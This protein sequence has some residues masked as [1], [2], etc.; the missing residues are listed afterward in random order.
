MQCTCYCTTFPTVYPDQIPP[1]LAWQSQKLAHVLV[2]L[3]H[4]GLA[5]Q[6]QAQLV[7]HFHA[8]VLEP[9]VPA[10][11]ADLLLDFQPQ[12][13]GHRRL[14]QLAG[15]L[16][17]R[18]H[19]PGTL[20]TRFR[21]LR[22]GGRGGLRWLHTQRF[23][24][25]GDF[26]GGNPVPA[27]R[28]DLMPL[29]IGGD[30]LFLAVQGHLRFAQ[31]QEYLAELGAQLQGATERTDGVLVAV[32]LLQQ[33]AQTVVAQLIVRIILGHLAELGDALFKAVHVFS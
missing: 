9:G 17:G 27:L 31:Q 15:P 10:V 21:P 32:R 8:H 14:V 5:R 26:G 18:A 4:G 1:E 7:D 19:Q 11:R 3:G 13:V 33:L 22:L 12:F 30:R 25:L 2:V 16:A 29:L 6:V 20:E 23:Q 24:F 28:G